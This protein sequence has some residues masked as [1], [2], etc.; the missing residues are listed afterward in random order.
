MQ[1]VLFP[2]ADT[3]EIRGRGIII[4]S[5]V[6]R[7]LPFGLMNGQQIELRRPD[8]TTLLTM[9]RGIEI[10]PDSRAGLLLPVEVKLADVP[11]GTEVWT[12]E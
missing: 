11:V 2:V 9:I 12:I 7:D 3:L 4:V 1:T 8:G 5:P 10:N 6:L